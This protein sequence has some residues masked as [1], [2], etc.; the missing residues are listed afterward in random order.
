[1]IA[2]D[3]NVVSELMSPR[4]D[5]RVVAWMDGVAPGDLVLPA[6]VIGELWY[7][8]ARLPDGH[9]RDEL[10]R[11]LRALLGGPLAARIAAYDAAAAERYGFLVAAREAAG[12]ATSVADGQIAATCLAHDAALATRNVK[13]FMG[14]GVHV[15]DPWSEADPTGA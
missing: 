12:R 13:D 1:V 11:R 4:P 9:R 5:A 8:V 3:T 15:V 10:A 14:T 6:V 7:G 2:L